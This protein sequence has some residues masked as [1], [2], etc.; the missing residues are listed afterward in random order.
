MLS[1]PLNIPRL[2]RIL[3]NPRFTLFCIFYP[4]SIMWLLMW[5]SMVRS[6][7]WRNRSPTNLCY[8]SLGIF[9]EFSE[10]YLTLYVYNF[11]FF[12]FFQ[13]DFILWLIM[14]NPSRVFDI[15]WFITSA[16]DFLLFCFFKYFHTIWVHHGNLWFICLGLAVDHQLTFVSYLY[17]S[18][19][20]FDTFIVCWFSSN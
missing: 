14:W 5:Q 13:C 17:K 15:M 16:F 19:Y 2:F 11:A 6:I 4:I 12:V 1:T 9:L 18:I 8:L 20:N 10:F 7:S 3:L